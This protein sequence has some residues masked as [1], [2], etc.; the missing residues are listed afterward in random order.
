MSPKTK[1]LQMLKDNPK[2]MRISELVAACEG[3]SRQSV[4]NAIKALRIAGEITEV[5]YQR[6]APTYRDPSGYEL[7]PFAYNA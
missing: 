1:I 4:Y 5:E 7:N 6:Y 2:A 3:H